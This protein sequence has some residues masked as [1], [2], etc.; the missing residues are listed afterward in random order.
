MSW[1]GFMRR[2]VI[3][4]QA[5]TDFTAEELPKNR[6]QVLKFIYKHRALT[7]FCANLI[8]IL[9]AIPFIAW[10][11]IN[12]LTKMLIDDTD[13]V[14]YFEDLKNFIIES[15]LLRIPFLMLASI[16]LAGILYIVRK[17]CWNEPISIWKDFG[18]GIKNSWKANLGISFIL[19]VIIFMSEFIINSFAYGSLTGFSGVFFLVFMLLITVV[20]VIA[21]IYAFSLA[22]LYSMNFISLYKAAFILA[23]KTFFYN[24]LML[25]A[26][27]LPVAIFFMLPIPVM[28][29]IGIF[30]VVFGGTGYCFTCA[31]LFIMK[32][33]DKFIN[34][35]Y[36]PEFVDKGIYKE[37]ED[38]F[39]Q[40]VSI[41]DIEEMAKQLAGQEKTQSNINEHSEEN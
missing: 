14:K 22:S 9:F 20:G 1:K 28:F 37:I 5:T 27:F 24:L 16:G 41:E 12:Y 15:N 26:A 31:T 4:K 34:E 2:L 13:K 6:K 40:D 35:K 19:G 25:I 36:Y 39:E 30:V 32:N 11:I 7:L 3:G 38:N 17:L 29:Y 8:F 21:S 18:K 23:M 10:E 33:F